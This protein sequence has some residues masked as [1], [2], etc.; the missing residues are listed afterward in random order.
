MIISQ[1][2]QS[3]PPS[4]RQSSSSDNSMSSSTE[5]LHQEHNQN[6]PPTIVWVDNLDRSHVNEETSTSS[7][8]DVGPSGTNR[9]NCRCGISHQQTPGGAIRLS[10]NSTRT[11]RARPPSSGTVPETSTKTTQTEPF[12]VPLHYPHSRGHASFTVGTLT[13]DGIRMENVQMSIPIDAGTLSI[14]PPS[15]SSRMADITSTLRSVWGSS[16]NRFP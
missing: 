2:N 3:P 5:V 14:H 4:R 15:V 10:R 9:R 6:R 12:R 8:V 13:M 1:K 11:T 16:Q 7:E